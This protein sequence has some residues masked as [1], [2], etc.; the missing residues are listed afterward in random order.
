MQAH[1]PRLRLLPELLR[2]LLRML[3]ALSPAFDPGGGSRRDGAP[4]FLVLLRR[5]TRGDGW[6]AA[7]CPL[8]CPL[9][10][11]AGHAEA[12]APAH[13]RVEAI[14]ARCDPRGGS[15]RDGGPQSGDFCR[16][17]TRN[18]G[19]VRHSSHFSAP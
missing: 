6:I 1:L 12:K 15:R 18:A 7:E 5:L 14:P 9:T 19:D 10:R 11:G 17:M 8:L 3:A 4:G 2:L 16:G 13:R